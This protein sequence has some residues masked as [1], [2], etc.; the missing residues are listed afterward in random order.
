[1]LTV[2]LLGPKGDGLDTIRYALF[3]ISLVTSVIYL[4]RTGG[5]WYPLM[6]WLKAVPVGALALLV[7]ISI[8]GAPFLGVLLVLALAL[9]TA[10][11]VF[12]ALKDEKRWFVFGLGAFL[13]AHLAFIAIFAYVL[14]HFGARLDAARLV[15][16]VIA[17]ILALA[18]FARLRGGLGEMAVPVAVYMAVIVIM[19]AGALTVPASTPWIA[20]GAVLFMISDAMIAI[21]RFGAPFQAVHHLIWATYYLAQYFLMV[22]ILRG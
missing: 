19:V 18:L 21:S 8:P 22:G 15:A 11:D 13:L 1:M 4:G 2:P 3:V 10:G 20:L 7:A 9:S 6:P 16:V 5:A 17:A 12:L 14:S